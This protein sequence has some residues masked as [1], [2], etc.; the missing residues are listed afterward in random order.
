MGCGHHERVDY[1]KCLWNDVLKLLMNKLVN[2]TDSTWAT[3]T[4][5]LIVI[6]LDLAVI[7]FV[8]LVTLMTVDPQALI[9]FM[10]MLGF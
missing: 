2:F 5:S 7:D 9:C 3:C 4:C 8:L 6:C 1:I 10:V